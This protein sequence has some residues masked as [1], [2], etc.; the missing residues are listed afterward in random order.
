MTR[1]LLAD[2]H[3]FILAGVEAVLLGSDYE[4]VAKVRD[5]A[6][7]LAALDRTRPDILILDVVMPERDGINVLETLRKRRDTRPVV[8]L[9]A[10]LEDRRLLEAI[11]AGVNGILLKEGAEDILVECLDAVR[12]GGRWIDK[13]M[14]QRAL[15]LS[16]EG[17]S[18]ND[19]IGG[20]STRER[21]IARLV[22]QGL[23]NREIGEELAI[24]EGTVK[25]YL[26]GI[27]EKLRIA[28]RTELAVLAAESKSS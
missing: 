26:H 23:R 10:S 15:D 21:A 14:L 3:P 18:T 22:A 4:V 9:T 25:V 1:V 16:I 24:T 19:P 6:A 13:E 8:L 2:D 5:G 27:Y 20:L 7:V 11:K 12:G 17:D 28:N